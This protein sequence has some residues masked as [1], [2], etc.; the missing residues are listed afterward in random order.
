MAL[1]TYKVLV[2]WNNDGD[3]SDSNEDVSANVLAASF[4]R[5]ANFASQLTGRAV[6]GTLRINLNN[7]TGIY[8]SFLSGGALYGNL[9][10]SR[11]IQVKAGNSGFP[12]TFPFSFLDTPIWTGY[13]TKILPT[14]QSGQ[15]RTALIEAT[16]PLGRLGQAKVDVAQATAQR[17][18]QL[19]DDILDAAGWDA[20]DR[21]LDEGKTTITRYW[22]TGKQTLAALNEIAETEVGWIKETPDGKIA[23]ENRH[24]RYAETHAN[25]SQGTFSDAGGSTLSYK[26]IEQKDSLPQ[27]FNSFRAGARVYTVG[28]LAV[29]WTLPDIGTSSPSIDVGQVKT[30]EASFPNSDSATNAVSVNAWTTTAATTDMLANAASDGSG[31]NLTSSIGISVTKTG[32]RME[33]QL[34]NNA[35]VLVYITKLQ[36]RG[37]PITESNVGRVLVQDSASITAYG[38]RE[39]STPAKWLPNADESTDYCLYNINLYKDV[40]PRVSITV[41][42]KD[43]VHLNQILQRDLHD[44]ITVTATNATRTNL[45]INGDFQIDKINHRIRPMYHEVQWELTPITGS[46]GSYWNVGFGVLDSST[47]LGY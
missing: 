9:L 12:Y 41:T 31:T 21:D 8:N 44:R 7:S 34:T 46:Y 5:G 4:T 25:T 36:A 11:K 35:A 24:H 6:A 3:F 18:D 17:T 10:P 38:E 45:G 43:G 37:T 23:F 27:V 28:S 26:R 20:G 30:F 39:Y 1:A 2:D 33:I 42:G 22:S 32:E 29:L 16:G 47:R 19:I 13:I 15:A 14:V 40:T